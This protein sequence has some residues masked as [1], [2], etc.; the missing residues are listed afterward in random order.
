VTDK[1]KV[2]A[3]TFPPVPDA[4]AGQGV[5]VYFR[6]FDVDDPSSAAAPVDDE[7]Q[8]TDN[9]LETSAGPPQ[10]C[11]IADHGFLSGAPFPT[12]NGFQDVPP[13]ASR[14]TWRTHSSPSLNPMKVGAQSLVYSTLFGG[15][16]TES[17]TA[18]A[19]DGAAN[20]YAAGSTRS[21]NLPTTPGVYRPANPDI[22]QTQVFVT[23]LDTTAIGAASRRWATYVGPGIANDIALDSAGRSFVAGPTS[24]PAFPTTPNMG[25]AYL[26]RSKSRSWR[27]RS[28]SVCA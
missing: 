22:T 12:K 2:T 9:C 27:R 25:Y 1:V 17:R 4:P 19:V 6:S 20:A 13:P 10:D 24:S 16:N 5:S 15:T 26:Q 8:P 28:L 3:T 14:P 11:P 21:N 23:K 18:L 7:S